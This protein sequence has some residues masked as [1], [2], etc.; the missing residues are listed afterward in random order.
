MRI[1]FTHD[2]LVYHRLTFWNERA[3]TARQRSEE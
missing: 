3:L 2:D 1:H